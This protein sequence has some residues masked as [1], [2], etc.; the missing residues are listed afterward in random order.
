MFKAINTNTGEVRQFDYLRQ[1]ADVRANG[2]SAGAEIDKA[3]DRL[4]GTDNGERRTE[5]EE[6]S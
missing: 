3:V 5:N 1:L 2:W 6:E 4:V